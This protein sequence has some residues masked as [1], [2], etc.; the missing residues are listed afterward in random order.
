MIIFVKIKNKKDVKILY[1]NKRG[2][3]SSIIHKN[4]L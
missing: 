2:Y 3:N 4:S 1:E